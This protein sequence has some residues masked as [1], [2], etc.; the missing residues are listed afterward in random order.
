[1]AFHGDED[2][3]ETTRTPEAGVAASGRRGFFFSLG[4]LLFRA[5]AD[6][7]GSG[8]FAGVFATDSAGAAGRGTGVPPVDASGA[9]DRNGEVPSVA[10][11]A[12][13][14]GARVSPA[15]STPAS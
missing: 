12:V 14:P 6:C 13:G 8:C 9:E 5:R 2:E 3:R 10:A 7:G 11:V 4:A 15:S 1:M